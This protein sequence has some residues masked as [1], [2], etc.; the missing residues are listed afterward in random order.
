[1]CLWVA[2]KSNGDMSWKR[3]VV[4]LRWPSGL[5]RPRRLEA[6][7]TCVS[8]VFLIWPDAPREHFILNW[9][10]TWSRV[11]IRTGCTVKI[12]DASCYLTFAH[13]RCKEVWRMWSWRSLELCARLLLPYCTG[14]DRKYCIPYRVIYCANRCRS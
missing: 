11:D 8:F 2:F 14:S 9:Y 13:A 1:V 7:H 6:L 3:M 12:Q 5:F 4:K 10:K